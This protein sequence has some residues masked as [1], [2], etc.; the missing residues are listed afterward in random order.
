MKT[1]YSALSEEAKKAILDLID[2]ARKESLTL[3]VVLH[4]IRKQLKAAGDVEVA[5][6]IEANWKTFNTLFMFQMPHVVYNGT[7]TPVVV[8]WVLDNGKFKLEKAIKSLRYTDDEEV[9]I[10]G[11]SDGRV[12]RTISKRKTEIVTLASGYELEV[13]SRDVEGNYI[14]ED[15]EVVFVPKAKS[16]WGFTDVVIKAFLAAADDLLV[17]LNANA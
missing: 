3:P 8:D 16:S 12:S 11:C 5:K 1:N 15:E 6:A 14:N 7:N 2:N 17:S 13:P 9:T 10:D 4:G